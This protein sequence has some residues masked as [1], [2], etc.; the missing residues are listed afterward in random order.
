MRPSNTE[1]ACKPNFVPVRVGRA[2]IIHLGCSLPNSS[3]DLPETACRCRQMSG[4][5]ILRDSLCG[6]APRGVYLAAPVTRHAGELLPH[7]FTLY[8]LAEAGIFSVALVVTLLAK[9]PGR[10]PARCPMVFG[11]SSLS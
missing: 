10:Y 4:L 6:L 5:L 7:R 8:L 1:Q 9:V 3:S 2:A 11:L